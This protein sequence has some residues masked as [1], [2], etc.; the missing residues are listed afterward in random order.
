MRNFDLATRLVTRLAKLVSSGA[1]CAVVVGALAPAVQA[2]EKCDPAATATKYPSLKGKTISMGQSPTSPPYAFIEPPSE[3]HTGF[4]TDMARELFKCLGLKFE[5]KAGKW[6]GL[7]P[8]LIA[9]QTDIMWSN[10]FYTPP[11]AE[12]VDFVTY[13]INATSG[14]VQK[15]NPKKVSTLEDV[16]GLRATGGLGTVEEAAF[17]EQSKKCE[18]AG[19]KPVEILQHQENTAGIRL[20]QTDRAD[21]QLLDTGASGY[22]VKKLPNELEIAFTN[23]TNFKVAVGINKSQPE[24]R[25]A[26]FDAM[27]I[28]QANGTQKQLMEKYGI[29]PDLQIPTEILTK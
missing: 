23:K 19:K 16:C 13:R 14:L 1:I 7:L 22:M 9:G 28:L 20:L 5:I 6:S 8:A 3:E 17:R 12:Q 25:Q 26:I 21:V 11:R 10:L 24:L 27:K 18:A 2:Q 29:D 15:G 4:D